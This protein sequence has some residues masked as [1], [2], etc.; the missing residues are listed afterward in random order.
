MR[1]KTWDEM[2]DKLFLIFILILWLMIGYMLI[3]ITFMIS[4]KD[5]E[6]DKK[7]NNLIQERGENF[8]TAKFPPDS[9]YYIT[10]G[11]DSVW[12]IKK[13]GHGMK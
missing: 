13:K 10:F 7:L 6:I 2:K 9:V 5:K 3:D 8:H 4:D 11:G 12:Y 1:R